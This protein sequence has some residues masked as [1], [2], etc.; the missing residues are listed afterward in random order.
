MFSQHPYRQ[1]WQ[2]E[3]RVP[4][5]YHQHGRLNVLA[6]AVGVNNFA[7]TLARIRQRQKQTLAYIQQLE[8]ADK[9]EPLP[10]G[11][12]FG[13]PTFQILAGVPKTG[14]DDY[15]LLP[16]RPLSPL[17]EASQAVKDW[18]VIRRGK[19]KFS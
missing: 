17:P 12:D 16:I 13:V 14:A 19:V 9:I 15:E 8:A 11:D 6:A 1:Q 4:N 5:I 2:L 18:K 10:W 3:D 7:A